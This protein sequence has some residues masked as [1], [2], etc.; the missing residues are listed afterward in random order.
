MEAKCETCVDAQRG[1]LTGTDDRHAP[2]SAPDGISENDIEHAV[3]NPMVIE[4]RDV[5]RDVAA[6][7]SFQ[8]IHET[9][10]RSTAPRSLLLRSKRKRRA[11]AGRASA[12]RWQGPP[13]PSGSSCGMIEER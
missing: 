6:C 8:E 4:T 2:K 13:L 3:A 10:G 9:E 7:C 1:A 12:F 5:S 11:A